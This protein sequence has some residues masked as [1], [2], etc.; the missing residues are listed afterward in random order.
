MTTTHDGSFLKMHRCQSCEAMAQHAAN[1]C[2]HCLGR[3]FSVVQVPSTGTLASWTTVRKPPL[4]FK[5]AG[6]YHVAVI[7]LD[8]GLRITG[9]LLPDDSV[10]LGDRVQAVPQSDLAFDVP[11]F[12]VCTHG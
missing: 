9:W 10:Q 2:A 11:V 8:D 4:R 1:V 5:E 3:T 7:D 6:V 12:K